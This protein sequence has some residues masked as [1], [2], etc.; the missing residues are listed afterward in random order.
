MSKTKHTPEPWS[1]AK[2]AKPNIIISESD[3]N[4]A[5]LC[6]NACEGIENDEL[7]LVTPLREQLAKYTVD[8]IILTEKL[9]SANREYLMVRDELRRVTKERYESKSFQAKILQ[10]QIECLNRAKDLDI[11]T[12]HRQLQQQL[13]ELENE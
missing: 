6:V 9:E 13:K 11:L 1:N 2:L 5:V 3:W 10:V 7:H 12:V 4:R 8:N